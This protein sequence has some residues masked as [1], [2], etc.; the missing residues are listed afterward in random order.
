MI[1]DPL[2]GESYEVV[3]MHAHLGTWFNFGQVPPDVPALRRAMGCAGIDAMMASHTLGLVGEI[4]LGNARLDELHRELPELMGY[5]AVNPHYEE[6]SLRQL[7][8][9]LGKG[10][11]HGMKMH[12]ETHVYRITDPACQSL[13]RVA[14][15]ARCPVLI[16]VMSR[17]AIADCA[18]IAARYPHLSLVMGHSG[19]AALRVQAL[20]TA[21]DLPNVYFDLT[22]SVMLENC[23]EW[24]TAQVGARRILFGTDFPFIDP[25]HSVGQVLYSRL[26][27][28]EKRSIFSENARRI[29]A[30]SAV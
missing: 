8:R 9:W 26:T 4:E 11:F 6:A 5:V 15:Q 3:D 19:G 17:E 12:P 28:G 7:D 23:L 27:P 29:L 14:D 30:G 24:M 10:C 18:E 21:R 16:H 22:A 1:A 2:T 13:F 25:K 20:E